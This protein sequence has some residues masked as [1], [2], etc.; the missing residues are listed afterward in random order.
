MS[1][2]DW[3]NVISDVADVAANVIDLIGDANTNAPPYNLA[4]VDFVPST[5][6]TS[7][8][9][10]NTS[11]NEIVLNYAMTALQGG[12]AQSTSCLV[13][14]VPPQQY[15]DAT[16][17][18]QEFQSGGQMAITPVLSGRDTLTQ[19]L[20]FAVKAVS[21]GVTLNIVGGITGGFTKSV[22]PAT[23]YSFWIKST[24]P[25]LQSGTVKITAADGT[26]V[27]AKMTFSN[28]ANDGMLGSVDLPP[29]LQISPTVVD[30][31]LLLNVDTSSFEKLVAPTRGRCRPLAELPKDARRRR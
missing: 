10:C 30:L 25:T 2:S 19:A 28:T 9:A 11:Q 6:N 29:G 23:G 1:W 31:S 21:I 13:Q 15:Y 22:A 14:A 17:N 3:L 4:G 5:G 8:Y 24:G 7:I 16:N 20:A 26:T 12:M 18:I 27:D